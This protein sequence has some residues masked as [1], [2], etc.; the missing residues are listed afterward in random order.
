MRKSGH[1]C[2]SDAKWFVN[3]CDIE[4][5][6]VSAGSVYVSMTCCCDIQAQYRQ[7]I[8]GVVETFSDFQDG[9]CSMEWVS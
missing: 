3:R 5:H 8:C 1:G 7:G 2:C 9:L 4:V 6:I